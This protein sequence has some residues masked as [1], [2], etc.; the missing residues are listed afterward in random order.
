MARGAFSIEEGV[1]I[2]QPDELFTAALIVIVV[3][4]VLVVVLPFL[5]GGR[6]R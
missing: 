4:V 6:R 2:L 5:T 3:A 1:V